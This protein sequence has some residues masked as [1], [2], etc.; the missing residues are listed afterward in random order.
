MQPGF[1]RVVL[2]LVQVAR[3]AGLRVSPAESLDAVRAGALV[4]LAD[5]ARFKAALAATLV[6]RPEDAARFDRVFESFFRPDAGGRRGAADRL[7][8]EGVSEERVEALRQR[9]EAA[10]VAGGGGALSALMEGGAELDERIAAAMQR[11]Q[12]GR[13]VSPMQVGLYGLRTLDELGAP[14]MQRALDDLREELEAD[15]EGELADRLAVQLETLRRRV[16]AQ[17]REAFERNNPALRE[18]S[19]AARLERQALAA[20][21]PNEVED[22]QREVRRLGRLL[23]DRLER[24]RRRSRVGVLDARRT[25][26]LARRTAGVPMT[27]VMRR[28]RRDRPKLAVL[29]DVSDSVR[30]ASRFLLVLVYAMQEAFA[31]TRSFVFVRDLGEV[32]AL[33]DARPAEEAIALAFAGDAVNVGASSDYGR[34]LGQLVERHLD[35]IDRRTTVVILGDGRTNYLDPNLEALRLVKRR[36]ARVVW[37]NPEPRS[38]WGFGDSEMARYLTHVDLSASVRSLEELRAAVTRLAAKVGARG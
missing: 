21:G 3:R 22:V 1:D 33:F 26:R 2:E 15:G 25:L 9:I 34:S 18:T 23:R 4:G 36:A 11:A 5:R 8:A 12:V 35:S 7:R 28:R 32:T 10:Q 37:L 29:C 27:A 19:R 38:S 31:R 14:A 16:R 6:K 17:V 13:M 20:L 24:A 30:A